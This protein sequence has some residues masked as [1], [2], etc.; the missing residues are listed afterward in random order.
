MKNK[1]PDLSVDLAGIRLAN[2][3]LVASGTFGYGDEINDLC[4]V[5]ELG[6]VVTKTITLTPRE[7]NPPP[8]L[9]EVSS[10]ILNTIGLQN[11]GVERFLSEKWDRLS[12]LQVPVIV[13][14][15]G[16]KAEDYEGTVRRLSGAKGVA[17]IE[18]NLSCPNLKK[19][20]ICQDEG[21]VADIIRRVKRVSRVPVIA[22]L[23]PQVI[24]LAGLARRCVDNGADILSLVNTFPGMAIDI[25]TRKPKLSTVVGGMSGPAVKPLALRCVWEASRAVTVPVIGGGGIMT[26]DDAVEFLIAGAAAVSMGTALFVDPAR[27]GKVVR[28]LK[29]YCAAQKAA[30]IREIIGTIRLS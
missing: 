14:V 13:S 1:C 10:G 20:I 23:S 8:R 25:K 4:P 16:G 6:A 18:L 24:D 15:A 11:M 26:A 2:P 3:V 5:K 17:G 12:R 30:N 28:G 27:P 22:K 7:G 9:A 19:R 21:L 29:E